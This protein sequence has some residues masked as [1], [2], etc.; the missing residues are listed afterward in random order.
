MA[1]MKAKGL[2]GH[3]DKAIGGHKGKKAVKKAA[4]K[5]AKKR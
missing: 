4:K 3:R 2:T 5:T 1:A